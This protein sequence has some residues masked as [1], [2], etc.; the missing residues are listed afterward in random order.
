MAQHKKKAANF[1]EVPLNRV[2]EPAVAGLLRH[3]RLAQLWKP[4]DRTRRI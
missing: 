1:N 3:L 2:I 4:T